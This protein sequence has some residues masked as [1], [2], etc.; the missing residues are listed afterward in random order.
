MWVCPQTPFLM[1]KKVDKKIIYGLEMNPVA[2]I[3]RYVI[4]YFVL[5]GL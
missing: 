2:K 3:R 5:V 1:G 4:I